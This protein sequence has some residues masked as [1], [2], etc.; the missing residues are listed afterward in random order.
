MTTRIT[1]PTYITQG[2]SLAWTK[3]LDDY[4]ADEYTL[5][6]R[7][8]SPDGPGFDV[9]ASADGED[10]AVTVAGSVTAAL[11]VSRY[12]WQAWVTEIAVPTHVK[13]VESGYLTVERGFSSSSKAA[14]D[15]RSPAKVTLDAIDEALASAGSSDIVEYEISTPTGTRRLKRR[16]DL[17]DLRKH[18]AAIVARENAMKRVRAGGSYGLSI[19]ARLRND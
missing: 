4:P 9:T 19:P 13:M 15:T 14:V 10:H 5:V 12:D 16:S 8:R 6:Y 11:H 2:E 7:F 17:L 1:E 18:Y 3:T